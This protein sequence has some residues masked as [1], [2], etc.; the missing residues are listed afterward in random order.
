MGSSFTCT[1]RQAAGSNR[2]VLE[3]TGLISLLNAYIW[4]IGSSTALLGSWSQNSVEF[5]SAKMYLQSIAVLK[6]H[7]LAETC[8]CGTS[9]VGSC[10]WDVLI[11]PSAPAL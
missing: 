7:F 11:K 1:D 6:K 4:G 9:S 8:F 3:S 2:E 10:G 5:F